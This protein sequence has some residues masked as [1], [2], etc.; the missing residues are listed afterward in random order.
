MTQAAGGNRRASSTPEPG[1][2]PLSVLFVCTANIARSPYGERRTAQLLAGTHGEQ[3]NV[4]SA[5]TPG[6]PG[7]GMDVEMAA[8]LRSRGGDASGHVSRS[9]THQLLV[10]SDLVLTFEF[11]Q[12]LRIIDEWPDQAVKVFGLRQ[13]ADALGRIR[14]PASGLELLDQAYAERPPDGMNLD[15]V[16]PHRRGA[17]AA[18][19]CADQIDAVLS[20]IV[21]ALGGGA[22][23]AAPAPSPK[24]TS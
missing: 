24:E 5:G 2:A 10:E 18:R 11:A 9:L 21:P 3:L 12:R 15:V 23:G 20:V 7:R 17:P 6:Y 22:A 4:A 8:Q 16:D 19:A 13:F 1:R 14:S